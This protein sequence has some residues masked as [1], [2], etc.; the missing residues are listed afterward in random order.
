[1]NFFKSLVAAFALLAVAACQT[2]LRVA[3]PAIAQSA[4]Q[5]T[6]NQN[7]RR[8]ETDDLSLPRETKLMLDGARAQIETTKS[9]DPAY[10]VLKYPLGDVPPE[11]GV[12][13]DVVVRAMRAAK[14]DLQKEVHE[15]MRAN[16]AAYPQKWSL[17]RAD[18]NIDHRRVPNL[19]RFFERRGK[20]LTVTSNAADYRPGDIVSWDL[21]GAG[22][23][24]IGIVSDSRS[25]QT[26]RFLIIHNIG[27]GAQAE[28]VLF[29]WKITG[30]Y[31]YF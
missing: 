20:S 31:R 3:P 8:V 28:D 2:D 27:R 1:M 10:V 5:Q 17:K 4:D 25:P 30:H 7:S 6:S 26:K 21:N 19:M 18:A 15:D 29:D 14:V 9:Y 24:H 23:T 22:L 12:C 13:S 16:F 11:T